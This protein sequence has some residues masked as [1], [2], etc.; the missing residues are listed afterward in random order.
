MGQETQEEKHDKDIKV[1]QQGL[2]AL[3]HPHSRGQFSQMVLSVLSGFLR[4]V[5][6]YSQV[7]NQTQ[8]LQVST[9]KTSPLLCELGEGRE[10]GLGSHSAQHSFAK[11]GKEEMRRPDSVARHLSKVL[12]HNN[13]PGQLIRQADAGLMSHTN[14]IPPQR[15]TRGGERPLPGPVAETSF[16]RFSHGR[17]A[18]TLPSTAGHEQ[19]P[20]SSPRRNSTELTRAITSLTKVCLVKAMVFPV[21]MYGC[22]NWTTKKAEC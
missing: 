21:V 5:R 9:R 11:Q 22:E 16:L 7:K 19:P 3:F 10:G 1:A 20:P 13:N 12:I 2:C 18:S 17:P 15:V 6:L 8:G 4:T 14:Q